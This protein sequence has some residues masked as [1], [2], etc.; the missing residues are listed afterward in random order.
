[1]KFSV[2][3]VNWQELNSPHRTLKVFQPTKGG[4]DDDIS[5][6]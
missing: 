5:M 2:K 4:F 3:D 6:E 1:M